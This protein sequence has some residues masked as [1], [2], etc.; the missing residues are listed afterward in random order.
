[1]HRGEGES[2]QISWLQWTG[3][4]IGASNWEEEK[5]SGPVRADAGYGF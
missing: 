4:E 1:M 2:V 3:R 5:D